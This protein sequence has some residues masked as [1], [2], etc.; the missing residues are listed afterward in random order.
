MKKSGMVQKE[1]RHQPQ[2]QQGCFYPADCAGYAFAGKMVYDEDQVT[3]EADDASRDW[4]PVLETTRQ[5][6]TTT[7]DNCHVDFSSLSWWDEGS[8]GDYCHSCHSETGMG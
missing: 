8:N 1:L 2:K 7:C 6:F 5:E 3:G 4:R